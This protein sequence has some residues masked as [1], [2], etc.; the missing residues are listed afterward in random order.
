MTPASAGSSATLPGLGPLLVEASAGGDR[1]RATEWLLTNGLGGYAMGT[2]MGIPT[3][4]YH[5]MLVAALA[6]PVARVV[7]LN[8]MVETLILDP[9]H[10][11]ER[12]IEL[13]HFQF[14]DGTEH[15]RGGQFLRRFALRDAGTLA[16]WT[17]AIG[18]DGADSSS[19][20][21]TVIKTLRL[22]PGHN[23]AEIRYQ[24]ILPSAATGGPVSRARGAS[25]V[26][27]Q[28]WDGG[29][30][31]PC[32]SGI[33][34]ALRP[35]ISMR[36][37]HWLGSSH[38]ADE[39]SFRADYRGV[40]IRRGAP[41]PEGRNDPGLRLHL[42]ADQGLFT[43]E[44]HWWQRFAYAH[45]RDRGLDW[46]EDLYSPGVFTLDARR[47]E[48]ID[49]TITARIESPIAIPP[50][51]VA[52]LSTSTPSHAETGAIDLS[53]LVRT[54]QARRESFASAALRGV[55][56]EQSDLDRLARLAEAADDFVVRRGPLEPSA[57]KASQTSIIAGYPWFSD[58]GRDSMIALP[59]LLLAT[60]RLDEAHQVLSAFAQRRRHGL[61]PNCFDDAT[62][63]AQY[64]TVDASL[65]FL[66]ALHAWL[67]A[68]GDA[69]ACATG[70]ELR[71]AA[72]EIVDRYQ[73]GT[74]FGIEMDPEDGLISAGDAST[75]LTW[76]DAK[77][78]GVVFTPR[79]GKAIEINALWHR[80][81][82]CVAEL[83]RPDA[84]DKA[85]AMDELAARVASSLSRR[86]WIETDR[87]LA[88]VI[89]PA[90]S[91]KP[92]MTTSS[93]GQGLLSKETQRGTLVPL[94]DA[95][96]RPNQ[97]FTVSLEG[98]PLTTPM[99]QSVVRTVR[100]RLVT[101]MGLRTL[102][103]DETGYAGRFEGPIFERDRAYHNGTVWPWLMGSFAE[104]AMRSEGFSAK[105]R[106]EA[107]GVLR[108]LADAMTAGSSL[109]QI[110][111]V[112]DGDFT[113]ELPQRA[114]GCPAQAWS[115]AETLRVMRLALSKD[116]RPA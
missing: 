115:L 61:I 88:D 17:W 20:A 101:P 74:D 105:S 69:S 41:G 22:I 25:S 91:I 86:F 42:E 104:A 6:P 76:M 107:L 47:G 32:S 33:C 87:V 83:V 64:N 98:S 77:R 108:P 51:S 82:R 15:P 80:G 3:R 50:T 11:D 13:S 45:E 89:P 78:D 49:L 71:L 39:F 43:P 116:S 85:K 75:Q 14:H 4:R 59:G 67:R 29:Q 114:G 93:A 58:W 54:R 56:G 34:L 26:G 21:I 1:A 90:T 57:S 95:R 100:E 55:H 62:G 23:A 40:S 103:P 48:A 38:A 65:W 53:A 27:A 35:L 97:I 106:A 60:G 111:E 10:S 96:C 9:G 7:A 81:L 31:E 46:Q 113:P 24:V 84:P 72:L 63:Q 102:A 16:E 18:P 79:H 92:S 73:R 30:G 37:H 94:V 68:G 99:Q 44:A 8:A 112:Y 28:R 36:D 19:Q 52:S 109:G 5:A 12:R 66:H 2:A 110:A 70:S